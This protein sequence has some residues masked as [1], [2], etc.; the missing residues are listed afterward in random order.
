M[1]IRLVLALGEGVAAA[2]DA[3]GLQGGLH[4]CA[5][6]LAVQDAREVRGGHADGLRGL[7]DALEAP[8]FGDFAVLDHSF[9]SL[10]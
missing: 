4:P 7:D 8:F 9:G 5:A 10:V 2:G 3:V 1:A 6:A